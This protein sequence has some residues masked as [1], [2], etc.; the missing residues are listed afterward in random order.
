MRKELAQALGIQPVTENMVQLAPV[1]FHQSRSAI[2]ERRGETRFVRSTS[3]SSSPGK[4]SFY[5]AD[6]PGEQQDRG[7]YS[8]PMPGDVKAIYSISAKKIGTE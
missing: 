1:P 8:L 3:S 4:H 5:F 7:R 6:V 2:T